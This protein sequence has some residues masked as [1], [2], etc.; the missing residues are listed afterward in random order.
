MIRRRNNR[1]LFFGAA[2]AGL[3][4]LLIVLS[5]SLATAQATPKSEEE[6]AMYFLG[7]TMSR[8]LR[9]FALTKD[10]QQFVVQGLQDALAGDAQSLDPSTYMPKLQE[11]AKSRKA[12][13]LEK[14]KAASATYLAEAAKVEGATTTPS[15]LI[16][17]E[18]KA[19]SGAQPKP[20]DT[21]KVHYHGTLRDGSVF[22]SS[23]ERGK[24]AEFPLNRVIPCWTEGVGMMQVGGK[25][26]L[27]CPS[28]IAYGDR[29]AQVIPGGAALTFEVELLDIVADA[30][31]KK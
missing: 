4:G 20:T 23:V 8:S 19:G 26:K 16:Y 30:T 22:D 10:E 24:P 1:T 21:V 11:L 13:A 29:G 12:A 17:Q 27:V 6:K 2:A 5:S 28:D 9:D 25:A 3:A 7:I 15:G 14:E 31:E 18:I